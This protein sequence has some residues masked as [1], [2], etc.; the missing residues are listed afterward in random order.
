MAKFDIKNEKPLKKKEQFNKM[1]YDIPDHLTM[2]ERLEILSKLKTS[3]L[4][5]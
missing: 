5:N 2:K 4:R 1:I 3:G